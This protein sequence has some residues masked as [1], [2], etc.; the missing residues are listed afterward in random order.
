MSF[1]AQLVL[2][3]QRQLFDYWI[4]R[5][6]PSDLPLRRDINPAHFPRLL[7]SISLID[8]EPEISQC[9]VRLA[10]TRLREVFDREITGLGFE[11]LEWGDRRDYWMKAYGYAIGHRMPAQG[12]L[13]G[14]MNHKDHLVQYWLKL[15]LSTGHNQVGMV[16]CL[17]LFIPAK[18]EIVQEKIVAFA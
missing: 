17:D 11:Q 14:P 5:M 8:V 16:L 7:P 18:V 13:R 2:P 10:G 9:R 1:R 4:E 12:I 3:E 6:R 15:P